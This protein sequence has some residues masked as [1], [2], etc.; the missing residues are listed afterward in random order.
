MT[1]TKATKEDLSEIL[2]LQYLAYQSEAKLLNNFDIPPLK[3]TLKEVE[4]EY[5][6]GTILKALNDDIIVGSVRGYIENGVLY[7]GKL[8]VHP[9]MQGKGIGTKLLLEIESV[10]SHNRCELF[11]SSKS[12]KNLQ[13]YKKVGYS[14]FKKQEISPQ[15]TLLFLK[16]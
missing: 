4:S 2:Q 3:Q 16:K 8:F 11:T 12:E 7:I 13:L 1:I 6:N 5:N 10:Y 9:H 15:L 14:I